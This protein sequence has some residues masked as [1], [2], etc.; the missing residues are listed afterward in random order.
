VFEAS[1]DSVTKVGLSDAFQAGV[2]C[3]SENGASLP[4]RHTQQL[5][6]NLGGDADWND[7]FQAGVTWNLI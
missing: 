3:E 4:H 7:V 2:N 1:S 6:C 5:D